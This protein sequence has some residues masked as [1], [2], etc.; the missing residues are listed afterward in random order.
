MTYPRKFI[1]GLT[2]MLCIT[3]IC[4]AIQSCSCSEKTVNHETVSDKVKDHKAYKLGGEHAARLLEHVEDEAAVQDGLLDVRARIN[5]IHSKLGAQ[6][7]A[8]YERGFTDYIRENCDSLALL[9]F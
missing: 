5:N 4:P 1:A 7:S 2:A 3:I 8:D 9:L 6:S